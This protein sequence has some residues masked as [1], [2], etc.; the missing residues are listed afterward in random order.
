MSASVIGPAMR[1]NGQQRWVTILALRVL[2]LLAI[3]AVWQ[4]VAAEHIVDPFFISEPSAILAR[5][6]VWVRD[7][8][9]FVDT[10]V[11]L[12]EAAAGFALSAVVGI[13]AGLLLSRFPLVDVVTRPYIDVI[14]TIP[15]IAL[16]PLFVLWFGLRIQAKIALVFSV[17]VFGF[18]INA[19]AGAKSVDP[20]FV[21]MARSLGATRV[22][23]VR[24]IVLPSIVPWLLAGARLGVAYSLAAAVVGEIVAA[25]R[26][27]GYRIAFASGVLDT[28][29][30][31]AALLALALVAWAMN[32]AVAR[33]EARLLRWKVIQDRA[34]QNP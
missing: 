7:G 4:F 14:N 3:C 1:R 26:G 31:F 27:L 29:G 30:E 2:L 23:L 17:A 6:M 33:L 12:V 5:L 19:Y 28:A 16:A 20:E 18:L 8:S 25:N 22:Q 10:A 15:R 9:I 11:T 24:K 34:V 21:R 32:T 13:T